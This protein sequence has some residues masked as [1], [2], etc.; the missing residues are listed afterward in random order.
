MVHAIVLKIFNFRLLHR[1][2]SK[3]ICFNR[4]GRV[5]TMVSPS[6]DISIWIWKQF[7]GFFFG[8]ID[9][10]M[11]ETRD[12]FYGRAICAFSPN[13]P[14]PPSLFLNVCK[15]FSTPHPTPLVQPPT[16]Q[17]PARHFGKGTLSSLPLFPA[18]RMTWSQFP[19]M[20][21]RKRFFPRQKKAPRLIVK[22]DK[23]WSKKK[24][25]KGGRLNIT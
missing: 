21:K 22:P 2:S 16:Q 13:Q 15:C 8:S 23:L 9:P 12:K 6:R 14:T 18:E 19:V 24:V 1:R 3:Y 5:R 17:N 25:N 11:G 20:F 10:W 4:K 7:P